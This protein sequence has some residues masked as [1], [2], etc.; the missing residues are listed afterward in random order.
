[1]T[2]GEQIAHLKETKQRHIDSLKGIDF[3]ISVFERAASRRKTLIEIHDRQLAD[4]Y[5][6]LKE[7]EPNHENNSEH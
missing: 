7:I 3:Q 5:K 1:M 6:Q 2:L 4:L